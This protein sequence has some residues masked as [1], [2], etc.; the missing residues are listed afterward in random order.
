MAVRF[1]EN[2]RVSTARQLM[3]VRPGFFGY[4]ITLPTNPLYGKLSI[5]LI[6]EVSQLIHCESTCKP[7]R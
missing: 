3:V 2:D 1:T 7:I 6:F 4:W 5:T